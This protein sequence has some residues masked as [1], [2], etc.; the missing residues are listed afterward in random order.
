MTSLMVRPPVPGDS[1]YD[2]FAREEAAILSSLK[3]RARLLVDG[4][5]GIDGVTCNASEGSMYAF[6]AIEVPEK[7]R[8][9]AESMNMSPD[10][11]YALSLLEETGICVVPASGFSQA[12]GRIGFRTTFL[13]PADKLEIAG[14]GRGV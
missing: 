12:A 3:S 13:P 4:L 7:A 8:E 1:S 11:L 5:N 14:G 6:P 9:H 10:T 2:S